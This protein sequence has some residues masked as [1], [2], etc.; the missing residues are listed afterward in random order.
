M[1][2]ED[3]DIVVANVGIGRNRSGFDGHSGGVVLQTG[4]EMDPLGG[5]AGKPVVVA[6]AA[7]E[8]HHGP[9][10]K[11][12]FVGG[13][14]VGGFAGGDDGKPRQETVVVEQKV[15]FTAPFAVRYLAQS[16]TLAQRSMRVLSKLRSLP[17][18]SNGVM[19]DSGSLAR[20]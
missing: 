18:S 13:A 16:N 12:E 15:D 20:Q 14:N 19:G 3:D 10:R 7:V 6:V 5:E 17:G 1:P 2:G 11:R 8:D 4:H 9:F